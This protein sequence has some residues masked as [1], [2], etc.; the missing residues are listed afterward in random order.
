MRAPLETLALAAIAGVAFLGLGC[1][2]PAPAAPDPEP[3]PAR[4]ADSGSGRWADLPGRIVDPGEILGSW[5]PFLERTAQ[6]WL[7]DLGIE[8]QVMILDA[9]ATPVEELAPALFEQR[10]I[11]AQA[12]TGGLLVLLNRARGEARIEPSYELEAVYPDGLVGR[13]A[14]DQ[15]RPYVSYRA[16]GM[17][18]MDVLASLKEWTYVKAALGELELANEFREREGFVTRSLYLSGGAGAQVNLAEIPSDAELK[19]PVTGERLRQL[20]PSEDPLASAEAYLDAIGSLV[21]DP[22]LELYTPAT[23]VHAS[24]YPFAVFEQLER[25]ERTERSR[26]LR[27]RV[28]GDHAVVDAARPVN[29]F[30]PILLERGGDGLWRVDLVETWKNLFYDPKGNYVAANSNTP[31]RF[32]IP[33]GPDAPHHDIASWDLGGRDLATAI[34]NL[35]SRDDALS[36]FLLAELLFRNCFVFV[37]ALAH[38]EAAVE[39]APHDLLFREILGERALYLGFWDLAASAFAGMEGSGDLKLA[40]AYREL[41]DLEAAE[42]RLRRVLE[43]DP[44]H[45]EALGDLQDVVRRSEREREAAELRQRAQAAMRDPAR[46]N[47]GLAVSFDPARPVIDNDNTIVVDGTTVF[48]HSVFG[49][50]LENRSG[51]PLAIENVDVRTHGTGKASGMGDLAGKFDYPAGGRRLEPGESASLHWTWGFVKDTPHT[52]L[53]YLFDVCWRDLDTDPAEPNG[54]RCRYSRVD[55]FP[56]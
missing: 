36:R 49:V 30:V 46:R 53:S 3:G 28:Q 9:P 56:L 25:F 17:A 40:Q 50:I 1:R 35:E 41:G 27:V 32:G 8:V 7:D 38:Y 2:E 29:G 55:L 39:A 47:L 42:Q 12:P 6:S 11:G 45:G 20:Q 44:H 24:R 5:G 21:G 23:R 51:V 18:I 31:Y 4:E 37:E 14:A 16:V 34:E 48:D 10:Q 26:P 19:Q 13:L 22:G 52:Q 33:G 15:L 43:R 54:R